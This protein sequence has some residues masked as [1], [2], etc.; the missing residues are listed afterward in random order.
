MFR[1]RSVTVIAA[2][3]PETGA[4][5]PVCL[6]PSRVRIPLHDG[7]TDGPLVATLEVCPGCGTGHDRPSATV[8]TGIL[9]RKGKDR[10]H[11]LEPGGGTQSAGLTYSGHPVVVFASKLHALAC[12]RK[13]LPALECAHGDC[14]WPGLWRHEHAID[15]DE[16]TWR[17]VFCRRSH[18]RAWA[19]EHAVLLP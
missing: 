4:W 1:R 6:M 18:K 15:G 14:H 3:E 10:N 19:A 2:A 12:R 16:G 9:G 11:S 8:T 5:C 7:A 17:Y 13:G